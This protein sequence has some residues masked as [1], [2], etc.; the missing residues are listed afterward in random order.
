MCSYVGLGESM[1]KARLFF[2]CQAPP[3]ITYREVNVDLFTASP[4]RIHSKVF[5]ELFIEFLSPGGK[6]FDGNTFYVGWFLGR[7]LS[8]IPQSA[9][10]LPV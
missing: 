6:P 7:S 4:F 9:Y 8:M 1:E 3:S 10:P 5:V 2:V